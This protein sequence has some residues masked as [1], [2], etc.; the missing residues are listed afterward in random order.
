MLGFCMSDPLSPERR[1]I[2]SLGASEFEAF[3]LEGWMSPVQQPRL[4]GCAVPNLHDWF[5]PYVIL[6]SAAKSGMK[7]QKADHHCH[8][9][10]SCLLRFWRATDSQ[11]CEGSYDGSSRTQAFNLSSEPSTLSFQ[12]KTQ[13]LLVTAVGPISLKAVTQRTRAP[14]VLEPE[15]AKCCSRE[16]L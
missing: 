1:S 9:N 14:L 4:A 2:W 13:G 3:V 15:D 7:R 12:P 10:V 5:D 11:K 8:R 16:E 6:L